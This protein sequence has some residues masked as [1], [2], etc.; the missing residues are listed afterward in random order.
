M[1]RLPLVLLLAAMVL[2][3]AS[4]AP[5]QPRTP[6]LSVTIDSVAHHVS[7]G[8]H[9]FLVA[10]HATNEGP[11]EVSSQPQVL[12]LLQGWSWQV[13]DPQGSPLPQIP[14]G[15]TQVLVV[16]VDAVGALAGDYWTYIAIADGGAALTLTVPLL[17]AVQVIPFGPLDLRPGIPLRTFVGVT[18]LGNGIDSFLV[19]ASAS[20][21]FVGVELP[22]GALVGPLGAH[23]HTIVA[24]QVQADPDAPAVEVGMQ[25]AVA[26]TSLAD[27]SVA[28]YAQGIARVTQTHA[29]AVTLDRDEL[30]LAPGAVGLVRLTVTNEGNGPEQLQL[31][32]STLPSGWGLQSKGAPGQLA[33]GAGWT[34]TVALAV[35]P[36]ATPGDHLVFLEAV[37]GGAVGSAPVRISVSA[38]AGLVAWFEPTLAVVEPG[39]RTPLQLHLRASGTADLAPILSA[40]LPVGWSVSGLPAGPLYIAGGTERTLPLQL[41]LP[42]DPTLTPAGGAVVTVHAIAAPEGIVVD[43]ATT[44]DVAAR[45]ALQVRFTTPAVALNPAGD[46][47]AIVPFEILNLGNTP[48]DQYGCTLGG[49]AAPWVRTYPP[50]T[51]LPPGERTTIV[52]EVD[53]PQGASP[54][55]SVA[56]L[57]CGTGTIFDS[58]TLSVTVVAKD[59]HISGALLSPYPT[60]A[61]PIHTLPPGS[62]LQVA[63][64]VRYLV[65][66][67]DNEAAFPTSGAKVRVVVHNGSVVQRDLPPLQP[68][69]RL[70]MALPLSVSP[71]TRSLSVQLVLDGDWDA[72]DNVATFRVRPLVPPPSQVPT[73]TAAISLVALTVLALSI[74]SNE[75]FKIHLVGLVLVPLYSRVRRDELLDN[76]T[77]GRIYGYIEANP[78]EHFN[79]IKAALAVGNGALAYHLQMLERE[80]LIR[81]RAEGHCRCFYPAR[82]RLEGDPATSALSRL[83]RIIL[84]AITSAP[85]LSQRQV[86]RQLELAPSTVHYHVRSLEQK[87]FVRSERKLGRTLLFA[88]TALV[89][90]TPAP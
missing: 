21:P 19:E 32:S 80:G 64:G 9:T 82:M 12:G 26:A 46:H 90:T 88:T 54:G 57:T 85:G 79:A 78:G 73:A 6:L 47:R 65:L 10:L 45:P 22:D 77:R 41:Q 51:G 43:A 63:P 75:L 42:P 48:I 76:F 55:E 44:I 24:L 14:P 72:T 7:V 37:A 59:L 34:T 89:V 67:V 31:S 28:T 83:Q 60:M 87:G 4:A 38:V 13:R 81:S 68:R 50:A 25:I 15:Q 66:W 29:L 58:T 69:G 40:E 36:W 2:P 17:P 5:T 8:E 86:A 52:A 62:L 18:N 33:A 53:V 23:E 74:G 71:S 11:T 84:A 61:G 70:A 3:L 49:A 1:A 16:E 56:V 27:P 20:S 35:P 30:Q 39:A